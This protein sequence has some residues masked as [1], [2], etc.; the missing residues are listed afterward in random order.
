LTTL[1]VSTVKEAIELDKNDRS[2]NVLSDLMVA[3]IYLQI[4]FNTDIER[5]KTII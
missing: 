3:G 4:I 5:S 1:N 2:F